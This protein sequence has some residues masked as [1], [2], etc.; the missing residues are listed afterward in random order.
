MAFSS[1]LPLSDLI[2]LCRLLR[3]YLG[4]GLTV[5][6]VFRRLANKGSARMRPVAQRIAAALSR[7][8]SLGD[9]LRRESAS[10]PPLLVALGEVGEQTGML[11]EVFT[12]LAEHFT[13]QQKLRRQFISRITWPVTQFVLAVLVLSG[14][15]LILGSL[16]RREGGEAYDPL[17]FGLSGGSGALTFLGIIFGTL[18]VLAGLYFLGRQLLRQGGMDDWLL[19]LPA[20]GPCLQALALGR[21]C[22]ALRLTTETGMSIQ[23]AMRLSLQATGNSAFAAR[24]PRVESS[25]RAGQ[26]LTEALTVSGLFPKDFLE[27]LAVGEES[28]QLDDVLRHQGKH[29]HEEAGRH[30]ATLTSVLAAGVWLLVAGLIIFAIFRLFSS[31][32]GALNSA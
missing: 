19:R 28:G 12:E 27:S 10:F 22:M 5:M 24:S 7:G 8:D 30:L 11:P 14:L 29:F 15:I 18:F 6:D 3:H 25:L 2:D 4:G 20:V 13:Q 23:R 31:Y 26:E 9:A 21:F 16:K 1:R 32:L 17:G